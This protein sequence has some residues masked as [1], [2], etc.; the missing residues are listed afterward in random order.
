MVGKS[1][2]QNAV[3]GSIPETHANSGYFTEL[4]LAV[5]KVLESPHWKI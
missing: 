2:A 1:A 3:V 4:G 5:T